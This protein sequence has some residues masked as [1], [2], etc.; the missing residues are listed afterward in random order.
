M[1]SLKVHYDGLDLSFILA[2]NDSKSIPV[3]GQQISDLAAD[4]GSGSH[5]KR[6][7]LLAQASA[8][9]HAIET[10]QESMLQY[11][12]ADETSG[13]KIG[14]FHQ[15]ARDDGTP[16][17]TTEL[18]S[19]IGI[20]Q[21]VLTRLLRHLAAMGHITQTGID[22]YKPTRFALSLTI[23]EIYGAYIQGLELIL[24]GLQQMPSYITSLVNNPASNPPTT[25]FEKGHNTKLSFFE[26]V[27][28]KPETIERF[29]GHMASSRHGQATWMNPSFYPVQELLVKGAD[30]DPDAVFLV[31]VGGN[32]G[33]DIVKFNEMHP[34]VP[35]RLVLQDLPSVVKR[36]EGLPSKFEA[37]GHDFFQEQPVK[38][39]R[40]YSIHRVLHDWPDNKCRDILARLKDAMRPG[41]SRL[42]IKEHVI[43]STGASWRGTSLDLTLWAMLGAKERSEEDWQ[44]LLESVGVKIVKI[45]TP[46]DGLESLIEC[47]VA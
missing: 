14:L 2:P 6:F 43:R 26:Y 25:M 5:E 33:G 1:G 12:W 20:D 37:M 21:E 11:L 34:D 39:A 42:L 28:S 31:D 18:A 24:P 19:S 22:E 44:E 45:W 7:E 30:T 36:V 9:V 15:L 10:P 46:F 17:R 3:L 27:Y 40:A 35:G 32:T 16:K 29:A 41:Y 13:I 4:V 23:P 8:L 47:E 38:G